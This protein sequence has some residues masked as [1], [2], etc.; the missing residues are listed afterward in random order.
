MLQ[1]HIPPP[2][3]SA[4]A[5]PGQD[6]AYSND[7]EG[8]GSHDLAPPGMNYISVNLYRNILL[9]DYTTELFIILIGCF[10]D[11]DNDMSPLPH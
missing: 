11:T 8:V 2:V 9:S 6:C 1:L 4:A 7:D 5:G 3:Q 10:K